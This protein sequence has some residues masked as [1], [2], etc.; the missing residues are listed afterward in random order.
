MILLRLFGFVFVLLSFQTSAHRH[1]D[2]FRLIIAF[3]EKDYMALGGA[4][5]ATDYINSRW[6]D[7]KMISLVRPLGNSI[8]LVE[9]IEGSTSNFNRVIGEISQ[10]PEIR[11]AEKD[12]AVDSAADYET[13]IPS[14][15]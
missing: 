4:T 9:L 8:I 1:P 5:E 6:G 12:Y 7:N 14:I 10:M 3:H 2:T 13:N 15:Q 11:Y